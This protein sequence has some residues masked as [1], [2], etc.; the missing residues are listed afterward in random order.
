M[1]S[2]KRGKSLGL[3]IFM[4]LNLFKESFEARATSFVGPRS[5]L[6][7]IRDKG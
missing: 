4:F 2:V 6:E 3:K 5:F 7:E 1:N